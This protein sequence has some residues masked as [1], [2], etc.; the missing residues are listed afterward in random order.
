ME[1]GPQGADAVLPTDLLP[2]A[3]SP[4]RVAD[5]HLENAAAALGQLD[6]QFRLNIK[7][8]AFE[9]DA[10][11]KICAN[12]LVARF[13]IGQVQVAN[14]ITEKCQQLVPQRV[15]EEEGALI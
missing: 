13:H 3:I 15:P 7:C 4:A 2:L 1:N 9:R 11:E 10:L 5:G 6:R 8:G 12:H 14:E